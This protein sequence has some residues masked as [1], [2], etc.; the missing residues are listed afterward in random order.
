M[1]LQYITAYDLFVHT[2]RTR[3]VMRSRKPLERTNTP[4]DS[5]RIFAK[6]CYCHRKDTILSHD[7]GLPRISGTSLHHPPPKKK[8]PRC[9]WQI[10]TP[11]LFADN[12][13]KTR[14]KHTNITGTW[15]VLEPYTVLPTMLLI[16]R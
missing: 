6:H 2:I 13:S 8:K 5:P 12:L 10:I 14:R 16:M 1:K 15:K 3:N 11:H 7:K 9:I 4:F